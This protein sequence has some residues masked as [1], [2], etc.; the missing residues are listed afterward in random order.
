[1][2]VADLDAPWS[3]PHPD[4]INTLQAAALGKNFVN[5]SENI[6]KLIPNL[7]EH[8]VAFFSSDLG[9][10]WAMADAINGTR[11]GLRAALAA[12]ARSRMFS[13]QSRW[14]SKGGVLM[15]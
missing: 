1:M 11:K 8:E 9:R 4:L 5:L 12:V 14:V 7:D 10:D 6:P 15:V 3:C 2:A 13:G